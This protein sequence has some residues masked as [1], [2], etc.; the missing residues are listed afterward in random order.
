MEHARAGQNILV[1]TDMFSGFTSGCLLNSESREDLVQGILLTTTPLRN[2]NTVVVRTDQASGFSSV[3]KAAH[4]QLSQNG[5]TIEVGQDCNK[6]SNTLVD[7]KIQELEIEIR[8]L[9]NHDV[10]LSVGLLSRAITNLNNR[11]RKQ[12]LSAAQVHFSR[13]F[14]SGENLHLNDE[15]FGENQTSSRS[16]V[17]SFKENLRPPETNMPTKGDIVYVKDQLSKH[18][19]REPHLVLGSREAN[20][21]IQKVLHSREES[22]KPLRFTHKRLNQHYRCCRS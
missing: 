3:F 14:I 8:K 16:K 5:I 13:D 15:Q 19:A 2:S 4:P 9:T 17:S 1:T 22:D 6:N 21:T 18:Q 12:G 10:K 20:I 7:K 11:I